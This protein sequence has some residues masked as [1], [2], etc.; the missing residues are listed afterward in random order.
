MKMAED[1]LKA[2]VY[3]GYLLEYLGRIYGRTIVYFWNYRYTM[4]SPPIHVFFSEFN[5]I[6]IADYLLISR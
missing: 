4:I 2:I 3:G 6:A 5:D 1:E